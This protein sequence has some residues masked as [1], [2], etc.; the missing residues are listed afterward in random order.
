MTSPVDNYIGEWRQRVV[1]PLSFTPA[2]DN[3]MSRRTSPN[4]GEYELT[5]AELELAEADKRSSGAPWSSPSA[6]RLEAAEMSPR[7]TLSA[8]LELHL[9][10]ARAAAEKAATAAMGARVPWSVDQLPPRMSPLE[11]RERAVAS[12]VADLK[13]ARECAEKERVSLLRTT[14]GE[15]SAGT[16]PLV[17]A[18]SDGSSDTAHR[19]L[20]NLE[21]VISGIGD[22]LSRA[23]A[24][25]RAP[26]PALDSVDRYLADRDGY[27][28]RHS[29]SF[30]EGSP[31]AA[32][33]G[34]MARTPGEA[35]SVS[36][37]SAGSGMRLSGAQLRGVQEEHDGEEKEAA[38][39]EEDKLRG[40]VPH[41]GRAMH[42][43]KSAEVQMW[44]EHLATTSSGESLRSARLSMPA[45]SVPL[46]QYVMTPPYGTEFYAGP[47]DVPGHFAEVQV[48]LL[49]TPGLRVVNTCALTLPNGECQLLTTLTLR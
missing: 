6:P 43:P 38:E 18:A 21:T 20:G 45:A 3:L 39:E 1:R 15:A 35:K 10:R 40:G 8:D 37:T 31:P 19:H 44:K 23:Q 46:V 17:G 27:I 25:H 33:V 9:A 36:G 12:S 7:E 29:P 42:A 30:A 11:Q 26:P 32:L 41:S 47:L 14:A 34:A 5:S 24:H 13:K 2:A 49:D 22:D 4:G 16:P 48:R 28:K